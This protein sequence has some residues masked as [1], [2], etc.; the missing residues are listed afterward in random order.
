MDNIDKFNAY[1]AK[2]LA[3]LYAAFPQPTFVDAAF[4]ATNK[5]IVGSGPDG[6][7]SIDDLQKSTLDP[8]VVFCAHTLRWLYDS[9]YFV[10]QMSQ[11]DVRVTGA[12]L[13]PKS[14]EALAAI[15]DALRSKQTTG[16]QLV[17]FAKVTTAEA[18]RDGVGQVVGHFIGSAMRGF[19]GPTAS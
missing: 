5:S 15:P 3:A 8:D 14:L 7:V 13:T 11:Y 9:G 17:E 4:I 1:T 10:G 6:A 18:V 19:F 16:Q 12:V 2:I